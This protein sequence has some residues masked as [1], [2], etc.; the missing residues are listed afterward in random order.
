MSELLSIGQ[1][2]ASTGIAVSAVRYYDKVGLIDTASRVGGKRRYATDVVGRVIFIKRMQEV[3]FSLDEARSVLDDS[4]GGWRDLVD[5]KVAELVDQRDRLGAM[6]TTL[7][8]IRTCGCEVVAD[9]AVAA[10]A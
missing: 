10:S 7:E 2:A 6:I 1:V 8:E 5:D 9:C 4:V 3:G